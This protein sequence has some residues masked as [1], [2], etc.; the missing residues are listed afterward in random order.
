MKGGSVSLGRILWID[1]RRMLVIMDGK[2]PVENRPENG[3]LKYTTR[4]AEDERMDYVGPANLTG[5]EEHDL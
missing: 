5:E 2:E 3:D 1:E 4:K